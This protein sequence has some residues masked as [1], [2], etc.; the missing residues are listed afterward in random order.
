MTSRRDIVEVMPERSLEVL[1]QEEVSGLLDATAG[2]QREIL[3]RCALAVLNVGSETD[4]TREILEQY[5]DTEEKKQ[6]CLRAVR[7]ATGM[8]RLYLDGL[9]NKY[10]GAE[11]QAA[12]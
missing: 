2:R 8:R 3:R 10:L 6:D 5:A 11:Q 7:E 9:A 4:D 1:S 12:A